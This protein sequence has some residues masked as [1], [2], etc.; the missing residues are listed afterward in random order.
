MPDHPEKAGK[1]RQKFEIIVDRKKKT[2]IIEM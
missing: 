1:R 2:A